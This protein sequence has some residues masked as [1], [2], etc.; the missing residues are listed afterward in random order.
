[1]ISNFLLTVLL[2]RP[3]RNFPNS[4][5]PFFLVTVQEGALQVD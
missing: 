4:A 5:F 3:H 2:E 1:M